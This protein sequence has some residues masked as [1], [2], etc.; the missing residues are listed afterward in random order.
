MDMIH[1][2]GVVGALI[3]PEK[4]VGPTTCLPLLGILLDTVRQEA[5]LPDD[6]LQALVSELTE[7]QSKARSATNSS[8]RNLLS[9]IGKLSFACKVV[10]ECRIFLRWL[11]DLAH[12]VHHYHE[13][14]YINKEALLDIQWWLQ[15]ASQWNGKAFF[16]KPSW[17]P[18]DEFQ[19]Y[20]DAS[21]T[22]GYGAYWAGAWFCG[23]W[24][25]TLANKSIDWKELY[26]IVVACA[27]WGDSWVG[28]CKWVL[29]HCDNQA[30]T[31]V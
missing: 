25:P 22:V 26:A 3:K 12:S 11:L 27:T 23:T 24:P 8:K 29:F 7:F 5:Q 14:V 6:K 10:P 15:V 21:S 13:E 2:C 19:L 31:S 9:L 28:N 17:M 4:V 20:T 16:L 1:L 18:P 30:V